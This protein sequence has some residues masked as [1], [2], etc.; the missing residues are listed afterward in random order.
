[1]TGASNYSTAS[2]AQTSITAALR[3]PRSSRADQSLAL[4][5]SA[6]VPIELAT[7]IELENTLPGLETPVKNHLA[8]NIDDFL[9]KQSTP[10]QLF[11]Q[12]DHLA[13]VFTLQNRASD[14]CARTRSPFKVIRKI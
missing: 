14:L 7:K 9:A 6:S 5:A 12:I 8:K 2:P 11:R 13:L 1:M 4:H 3:P 10:Y